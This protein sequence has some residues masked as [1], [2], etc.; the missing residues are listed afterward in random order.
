MGEGK[1]GHKLVLGRCCCYKVLQIFV[2]MSCPS[3]V[4]AFVAHGVKQQEVL[5]FLVYYWLL[6]QQASVV[7]GRFESKAVYLVRSLEAFSELKKKKACFPRFAYNS[8]TEHCL[9]WDL[10]ENNS[11]KVFSDLGEIK[12]QNI[13][14]TSFACLADT[15]P[16]SNSCS[17]FQQRNDRWQLEFKMRFL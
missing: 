16:S 9:L 15:S 4:C 5:S 13:Q 11:E 10:N 1:Q 14:N 12:I 7:N 6:W 17:R 2:D 3:R 8:R